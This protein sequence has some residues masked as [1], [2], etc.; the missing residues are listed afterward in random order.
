MLEAQHWDAQGILCMAHGHLEF[1]IPAIMF[2][3]ILCSDIHVL[4]SVNYSTIL[5]ALKDM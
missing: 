4:R 2:E 3:D 5:R 1:G